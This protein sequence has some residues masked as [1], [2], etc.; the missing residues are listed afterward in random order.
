MVKLIGY[1]IMGE[2]DRKN[3]EGN[4][5]EEGWFTEKLLQKNSTIKVLVLSVKELKGGDKVAKLTNMSDLIAEKEVP[6]KKQAKV[7]E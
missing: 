3:A 2:L 4:D 6:N 1:A 7:N 5:T